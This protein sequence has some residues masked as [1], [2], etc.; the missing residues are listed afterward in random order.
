M[1]KERQVSPKVTVMT[2]HPSRAGSRDTGW[3]QWLPC[4]SQLRRKRP[5]QPP[6]RRQSYEG[7]LPQLP[8]QPA[9]EPLALGTQRDACAVT[10]HPQTVSCQ[11]TN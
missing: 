2:S 8:S 11:A 5:P 3:P 9:G 7:C 4:Q 1:A 10:A 6:G